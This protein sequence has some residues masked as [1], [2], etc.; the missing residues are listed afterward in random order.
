MTAAYARPAKITVQ[1]ALTAL[2]FGGSA[3]FAG[4]LTPPPGAPA[5][6]MKT[7]DEIEPR[8]PIRAVADADLVIAESG[9]YYLTGDL[10]LN[11]LN[12]TGPRVALDLNGYQLAI[13][14]DATVGQIQSLILKNGT[15]SA[16]NGLD[17]ADLQD[18]G[19]VKVDRVRFVETEVRVSFGELSVVD[20][21]FLGEN[22]QRRGEGL[23][24]LQ[25]DA[26]ITESTFVWLDT[27][28]NLNMNAPDEVVIKGCRF[29]GF[30]TAI[31][32]DGDGMLEIR[33]SQFGIADRDRTDDQDGLNVHETGLKVVD[34]VFQNIERPIQISGSGQDA[35][36]DPIIESSTFRHFNEAIGFSGQNTLFVRDSEFLGVF[37]TG[38]AFE[39]GNDDAKLQVEDT[40]FRGIRDIF[41]PDQALGDF[42]F[43]AQH[44]A[45][46]DVSG[47]SFPDDATIDGLSLTSSDPS[48]TI[49]FGE[50]CIAR[51]ATLA[52]DADH[53]LEVDIGA[54]S[55]FEDISFGESVILRLKG[56]FT[57]SGLA[58][59][60]RLNGAAS[61]SSAVNVV[62]SSSTEEITVRLADS[63]IEG[64][65]HVLSSTQG[66]VS[67]DVSG[68]TVR[69]CGVLVS[70]EYLQL[71][72]SDIDVRQVGDVAKLARVSGTTIGF[73]QAG[74][75]S[76]LIQINDSVLQGR[77]T[78]DQPPSL[79]ALVVGG[80]DLESQSTLVSSIENVRIANVA[81]AVSGDPF[82]ATALTVIGCETAFNIQ[83][84]G[85]KQT[86]IYSSLITVEKFGNIGGV[87]NMKDTSVTVTEEGI[88]G[89]DIV[90]ISCSISGA[91]EGSGIGATNNGKVYAKDVMVKG[92]ATG[93]NASRVTVLNSVFV[94]I[95][96]T[97]IKG[98][99]IT[100]SGTVV[101]GSGSGV[102]VE[103]SSGYLTA[104]GNTV[105]DFNN[106]IQANRATI[107]GN[108]F[109]EIGG[110]AIQVGGPSLIVDNVLQS[111]SD[112]IDATDGPGSVIV[113]NDMLAD[114]TAIRGDGIVVRNKASV[115]QDT[116]F[117]G[118]GTFGRSIEGTAINPE[119][120]GPNEQQPGEPWANIFF[121]R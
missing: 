92:F 24:L 53:V 58:M 40:Q 118:Q 17:I 115:F 61:Q 97:G 83:E 68:L 101:S 29:Y 74:L 6:T 27:A 108:T 57:A 81:F 67:F 114:R 116:P 59:K 11:T 107:K 35:S 60:A 96:Q 37:Q 36:V 41:K 110:I 3:A 109:T 112:G 22:E 119:N 88:G 46:R 90:L 15:I 89:D 113:G 104:Q 121:R 10:S 28:I 65:D 5:P 45:V 62:G 32:S 98:N 51:N 66:L 20:S 7:L 50:R 85:E 18:V 8:T 70:S 78:A 55:Q 16:D 82:N 93:L 49:A 86:G 73:N 12:I 31:E 99:A 69:N 63:H 13:A 64:Y 47:I 30:S 56:N 43:E 54:D 25:T 42:S 44:L 48:T 21:A 38:S 94:A 26:Q 33:D 14:N 84:S 79:T 39:I 72:D 1:L 95:G 19:R 105:A 4:S 100:A 75:Q 120:A 103:T 52:G 34:S 117:I 111:A 91:G 80:F 106:G 9:H 77:I 102:G 76:G 71:Q 23:R 2:I 87:L